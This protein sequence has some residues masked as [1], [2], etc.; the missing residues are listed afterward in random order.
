VN[1]WIFV[2]SSNKGLTIA[3]KRRD[4]KGINVA[5]ITISTIREKILR[6]VG[7]DTEPV[8]FSL[9]LLEIL[10]EEEFQVLDS[11]E[12]NVGDEAALAWYLEIIKEAEARTVAE[13]SAVA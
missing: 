5:K 1:V 7:A 2:L 6:G 9:K 3:L 11:F 12:A 13:Q 10:S 8:T 4:Q